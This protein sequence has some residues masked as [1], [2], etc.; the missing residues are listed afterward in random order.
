MDEWRALELLAGELGVSDDCAVLGFE[1]TNALLTTDM[2]HSETDIPDGADPGAVGWRAAAVSLSDVAAMGGEPQACV[3]AVG[4]PEF[5]E[6]WLSAVVG[7]AREACRSVGADYVGGDLDRHSETTLASTV[8]GRADDPVTRSG[9]GAGDLVCVTGELGRTA[10]ALELFDGGRWEEANELFRFA[11][12]VRE[13]LGVAPHA[14]AMM[15][16]SDGLA[17]SL[18]QLLE[19]G[20]VGFRVRSDDLPRL[21]EVDLET[22]VFAGG[23]YELVF[24]VPPDSVEEIRDV[25]FPVIGE[26]VE[27][28]DVWMDGDVLEKRGYEH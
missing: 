22:A 21:D 18:H 10:R 23:D 26:C 20:D 8:L 1:G 27:D 19:A 6:D 11:P 13:G 16:V 28:K 2:I 25:E 7:G 17:V 14:S 3:M 24:T 15:D 9:A 5:R 4:A 12:R